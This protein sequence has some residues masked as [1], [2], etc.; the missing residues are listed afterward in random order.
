MNWKRIYTMRMLNTFFSEVTTQSNTAFN[1]GTLLIVFNGRKT[2]RTRSDLI[3][4]KFC[5][6]ELPLQ[7]NHHSLWHDQY[8]W[9]ILMVLH[10]CL[11]FEICLIQF[12]FLIQ[13]HTHVLFSWSN[14][15]T[16]ANANA[17]SA[18]MTTMASRM[19]HGSRQYEPGCKITPW[20][21][22]LR[23]ISTVKTPVNA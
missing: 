2:L 12:F 23:I 22:T 3:V 1:L 6:V 18:H 11:S 19:F 4:L 8:K 5:P 17:I 9:G 21:N 10:F 20:S 16:Y 13:F 7:I 15:T 14:V